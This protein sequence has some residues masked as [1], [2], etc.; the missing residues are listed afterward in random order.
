M[1]V[2]VISC[3]RISSTKTNVLSVIHAD[4]SLFINCGGEKE[5]V[6][7]NC[8]ENDN[9]SSPYYTSPNGN[10]AYT[11]SGYAYH[12]RIKSVKCVVDKI[13]LYGKAR[14]SPV[15][16]KY[17]GF[18]LHEGNYTVTLY[19]AEIVYTEYISS[20]MGSKN[21]MFDIYVQVLIK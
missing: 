1:Y 15:Y 20:T 4:K 14:F 2:G 7:E 21:R 11:S 9:S 3:T 17:Y 16:L 10:W 6:G 12:D 8:Y 19:F 5:K 13:P 18:C